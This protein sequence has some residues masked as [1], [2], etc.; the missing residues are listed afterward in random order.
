MGIWDDI[1]SEI[2]KN[3]YTSM[4]AVVS[5]NKRRLV[6]GSAIIIVLGS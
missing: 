1:H 3:I 6:V 5:A 2:T 4:V